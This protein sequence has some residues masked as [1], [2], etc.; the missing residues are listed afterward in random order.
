MFVTSKHF[1]A[2]VVISTYCTQP[3]LLKKRKGLNKSFIE[4]VT[5]SSGLDDNKDEEED[6]DEDNNEYLRPDFCG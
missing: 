6:E 5:V 1:K 4:D 2:S 3:S